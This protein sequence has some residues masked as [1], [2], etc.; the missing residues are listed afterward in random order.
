MSEEGPPA[1]TNGHSSDT[2]VPNVEETEAPAAHEALETNGAEDVIATS[3]IQTEA[4]TQE[5]KEL[6]IESPADVEEESI[7]EV[8]LPKQPPMKVRKLLSTSSLYFIK[9]TITTLLA[10]KEAKKKQGLKESATKVNELLQ[11]PPTDG[12]DPNTIFEPLRIACESQSASIVIEALDCIGKL[13]AVSFFDAP[14]PKTSTVVDE[15]NFV[16]AH[17]ADAPTRPLMDRVIDTICECFQGEGTDEKVQL[18]IIKALLSAVLDEQEGTMIHQSPLLKAIRQTYN[19]F[20]LSRS[21][22]TQ[23]IAQGTLEQMVHAVFG[24]VRLAESQNASAVDLTASTAEV[25]NGEEKVTLDSFARRQSFDRI[26]DGNND[27]ELVLTQDEILVKDA[28]LIFRSMC[29]LSTK[30]LPVDSVNDLK[31]HMVRS[32]LLSLHMI[33]TI[34]NRHNAVFLSSQ[35]MIRSSSSSE[36]IQFTQATKQY[37]CHA[38]ARN[39]VSH[40]PQVFDVSCEIFWRMLD[41][42]RVHLKKE[43]EVFMIEIYLPILE[44]KTSSYQQKLTFINILSRLCNDPRALVEMYLNYDCDRSAMDNIYER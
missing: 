22:P 34:L 19:I 12:V 31:S 32:K 44:M 13:V 40:I 42:L 29:K 15:E 8:P 38:L 5:L 21:V 26:P 35:A 9:K 41:S 10:S 18:Q 37:L 39:A 24:R 33:S 2:Q 17:R 20:L 43:I 28:F 23:S 16:P 6:E 11:T 4:A 25:A 7:A 36:G 1:E 3:D 27:S 14:P 30:S